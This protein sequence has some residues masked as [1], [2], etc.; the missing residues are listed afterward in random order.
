M[1]EVNAYTATWDAACRTAAPAVGTKVRV[2]E[3]CDAREWDGL[4]TK[5]RLANRRLEW[6]DGLDAEGTK[7][8]IYE[9]VSRSVNVDTDD[10]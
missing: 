1:I 5:L 6:I 7:W 3:S 2:N 4:V 9:V 10:E 8:A